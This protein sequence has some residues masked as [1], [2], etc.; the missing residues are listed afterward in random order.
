MK[1]KILKVIAMCMA[2]VTVVSCL[3]VSSSAG[4]VPGKFYNTDVQTTAVTGTRGY[5]TGNYTGEYY[6]DGS[7]V[8][9]AVMRGECQGGPVSNFTTTLTTKL[10]DN[11]NH[12]YHRTQSNATDRY[13]VDVRTVS[14]DTLSHGAIGSVYASTKSK[15]QSSDK[16]EYG[17]D[18]Y[19]LSAREGWSRT[20]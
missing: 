5:V 2:L 16:W 10:W 1:K 18:Y 17:Y 6:A 20:Q 7:G 11:V 13:Y 19:W 4:I 8:N 14:S 3:V 12:T 9:T 15:T